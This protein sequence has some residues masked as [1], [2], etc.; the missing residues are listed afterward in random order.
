MTARVLKIKFLG[1]KADIEHEVL[2]LKKARNGDWSKPIHRKRGGDRVRSLRRCS[3]GGGELTPENA[4][5]EPEPMTVETFTA[6][7]PIAEPYHDYKEYVVRGEFDRMALVEEIIRRHKLLTFADTGRTW[8]YHQELGYYE[9]NAEPLIKSY[10]TVSLS[11]EA[12]KGWVEEVLY[13]V[14]QKTL[15]QRET[16]EP[17]INLVNVENGI[18]DIETLELRP[19]SSDY[20]FT[21]RLPVKYD[22]EATAPK[23]RR[24]LT[25]IV[26]PEDSLTLQE[27]TGY[28]LYR[29]YKFQK[30]ALLEG[31]GNNGKSTFV[32]VQKALLGPDNITA[33]PL[34]NLGRRF[35]PARLYHKMANL[36]PD[37][38]STALRDTGM[39]KQS[40][41]GD[42]IEGE[43]KYSMNT[44]KFV[45]Y[46]K[47]EY[48]ANILPEIEED[49]SK[50][51]YRRWMIINFP[52][53]FEGDNCDK[54]ILAKITTPDELSGV[55]NWALEG[56]HRLRQ[57][58]GFTYSKT[59]DEIQDQYKRM[60][61]SVY[62]YLVDNTEYHPDSWLPKDDLYAKYIEYCIDQ[63]LPRKSKGEFTKQLPKHMPAVIPKRKRVDNEG[64]YIHGWDGI[65]L[66][67][68]DEIQ[69]K[70][71][72]EQLTLD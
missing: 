37:L 4:S 50:A 12:R 38:S 68:P 60:S 2:E 59:A 45:S 3:E 55:L 48:S 61:S 27:F 5:T 56:L 7:L 20:F 44:L 49:N 57:N 72:K 10:A 11:V 46:C 63:N 13:L 1:L 66:L 22:P 54:N 41:G 36:Y 67:T 69:E 8:I 40:T 58:Q 32:G 70:K 42:M 51:F 24:F 34:Q 30:A 29:S 6:D 35:T 18:L 47:H 17:P 9:K 26:I 15:A 33:I 65:R 52:N 64:P 71:K 31:D 28:F 21:N 43:I 19:H 14:K 53:E 62:S 25:E 23:F 39:F 16:L